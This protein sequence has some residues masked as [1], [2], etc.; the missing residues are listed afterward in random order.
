MEMF[1]F[2]LLSLF[3]W[4]NLFAILLGTFAGML[5]GALPGLGGPVAL[6]LLLPVTYTMSPLAS[7]LLLLAAY[8]S[9]EYGGSISSIILGIPGGP[10]AVATTLDGHTFAKKH[11]PNKALSYSLL[12][13]TIG[14]IFG[15]LLLIF[16][17]VPIADFSIRMSDPEYFLLGIM[18]LIAV[19]VISSKDISKSMIAVVLGL[20]AG[21]IGMDS[22]TGSQRFTFGRAE[23]V[24]GLGLTMLM[25]SIFAFAEV[26]SMI[27]TELKK[28]NKTSQNGLD[29]T[30]G[31][32]RLSMQEIKAVAKPI[33]IG[34]IIGSIIGVLPGLGAGAASWFAY[35]AA[36]K[37]SKDPESFGNG[38]PEGIS[39]PEASNNASVGGALIPL[40]AL[41]IPGSASI[42]IV[43]GAFIIHGIQPGPNIFNTNGDLVYGIFYGFL[44]T[45]I[46]M[47]IVG[48]VFT[49]AYAKILK[50]PSYILITGVLFLSIIGIY[51]ASLLFF[52]LWIG[53]V[54]GLVFFFLKALNFSVASF[55]L[56]FILS[57]II[58]I[59]LRRSL[60]LSDGSFGIFLE[61]PISVAIIVII[62]LMVAY[63]IFS[64][65]KSKKATT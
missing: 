9:A 55:S 43:S 6:S 3:T 5:I 61:R 44:L 30:K 63:S 22:L 37:T 54:I 31:T 65:R 29:T 26:F 60:I 38:N 2:D 25:V 15:A 8:Q 20:M 51:S 7:I 52:D 58:E 12:A 49:N 16:L 47:Y 53:L 36:K 1:Q 48:R 40:L 41:G 59:S 27:S 14:G 17:T 56:E 24:D 23:L 62:V 57:P 42:A 11:S 33:S 28:K 13:S 19:S 46:V 18:G 21:T 50:V 35:S 39:A 32:G 34:S 4:S 10:A 45:T 64:L